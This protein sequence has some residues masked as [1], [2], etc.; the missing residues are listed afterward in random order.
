MLVTH[1]LAAAEPA[2]EI[3]Y[4]EQGEVVERG[5]HAELMA[6]NGA[7]AT[8]HRLQSEGRAAGVAVGDWD[9]DAPGR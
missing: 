1:D 3:L 7:Y 2:D 8:V 5:T 6:R 4:L 9:Q